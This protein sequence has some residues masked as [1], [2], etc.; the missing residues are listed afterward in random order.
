MSRKAIVLPMRTWLEELRA[1]LV[2]A[3]LTKEAADVA[4][5]AIVKR[6]I[7]RHQERELAGEGR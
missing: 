4:A 1:E 3:G 2:Q 7:T 6:L 5:G